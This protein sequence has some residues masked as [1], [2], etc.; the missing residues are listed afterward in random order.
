MPIAQS[1]RNQGLAVRL[2]AQRRG[3]FRRHAHGGRAL[4]GQRGVVYHQHR[5]LAAEEGVGLA[6]QLFQERSRI[7]GAGRDE[8]L[9]LVV[10]TKAE[11]F[12]H[13]VDAL[14]IARP[15]QVCD[16][17]RAHAPTRLVPEPIHEGREPA[18]EIAPPACADI[19]ARH[20]R[21]SEA[22]PS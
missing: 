21:P 8:V 22:D 10:G 4:L 14:A 3:V 19:H 1:G 20:D 13:G 9:E 5:A 16:G 6:C 7:P 12:G 18:L 11:P 2:L 17:E 15:D